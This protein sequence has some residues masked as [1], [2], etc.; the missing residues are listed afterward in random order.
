[1]REDLPEEPAVPY[2]LRLP[3][4]PITA[5][6][7]FLVSVLVVN[8]VVMQA[9]HYQWQRGHWL[10]RD[11]F[12]L[13]GEENFPTWYSSMSLFACALLL[14][15]IGEGKSRVQDRFSRHWYVLAIGFLTMSLDEVAGLHETLNTISPVSWTVPGAVLVG[16]LGLAY[17]PFLRHLPARTRRR[18][19][20]AG[21]VYVGGAV[22]VEH[23]TRLW[24]E[25]GHAI[26]SLAYN[27]WVAVEE[28][29]EM[30]GIVMF[31][32]AQLQY[33]QTDGAVVV[34]VIVEP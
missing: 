8:H 12:D 22:G 4:T 6:L 5:F 15:V 3:R 25:H 21:I 14:Y 19:I 31:I 17:V 20:V 16:V 1:M 7:V 2:R 34:P 11:A 18:F 32:D 29:M 30:A 33:L 26:D 13:D 24:L 10:L 9:A 28:G 27:L 23:A